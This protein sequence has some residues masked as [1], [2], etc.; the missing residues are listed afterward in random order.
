MY[1]SIERRMH[2]GTER[3]TSPTNE[4]SWMNLL[5]F[6]QWISLQPPFICYPSAHF[7]RKYLEIGYKCSVSL[8]LCFYAFRSFCLLFSLSPPFSLS[9][10]LTLFF[11]FV[12][13][14]HSFCAVES[15]KKHWINGQKRYNNEIRM[16]WNRKGTRLCSTY[17]L[18][19]LTFCTKFT[20]CHTLS[21][22]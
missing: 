21:C 7:D 13:S 10:L 1:D 2:S 11:C 16:A 6:Y 20:I 14:W 15:R 9:L 22:E 19:L 3:F 5:K 12:S 18:I 17:L 8:F 4:N